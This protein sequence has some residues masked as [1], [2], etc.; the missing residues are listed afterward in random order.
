[1]KI[2]DFIKEEMVDQE[3]LAGK[4]DLQPFLLNI[5]KTLIGKGF[6]AE[7]SASIVSSFLT[8]INSSGYLAKIEKN[9]S[10]VKDVTVSLNGSD[11][12]F[13]VVSDLDPRDRKS[14]IIKGVA[15]A[16]AGKENVSANTVAGKRTMDTFQMQANIAAKAQ[17]QP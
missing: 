4:S 17:R 16:P 7:Q 12:I 15:S 10:S 6:S 1:M 9:D 8:Q 5:K 11:V 3:E 2:K 13:S 14:F